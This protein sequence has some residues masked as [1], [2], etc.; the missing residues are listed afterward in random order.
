MSNTKKTSVQSFE[1]SLTELENIVKT[2]DSG[3]LSLEASLQAFEQG[4][5]LIRS[6][7][8]QL[9]QAEQKVKQ[10]IESEQ[11]LVLA[12]FPEDTNRQYSEANDDLP[13]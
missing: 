7:Q 3:E 13:F 8:S 10:L 5:G 11:G 2:M 12:D 1:Q 6:C 4:I 9:Q